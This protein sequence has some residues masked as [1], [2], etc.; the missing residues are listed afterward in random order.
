MIVLVVHNS[1]AK[2]SG[3]ETAV[4]NTVQLLSS[5]GHRVV[6]YGKSSQEISLMHLG[7]MWA[8]FSGIYSFKARREFAGLLR[9][10]RPDIVHIHNLFPLISP[11]ILP[12]C[13]QMG[14]PVVMSVHNYRLVCPDGLFMSKRARRPC[15]R[16]LGGR[17]YWCLLMNCE[18]NWCKSIG[19]AIRNYVARSRK[20]FLDNVSMY[21]CLT[22]F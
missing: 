2:P 19:Y 6:V 18:A 10:A 22:A 21:A 16:C 8:F 12:V 13:R 11:S 14:I 3:E 4:A 15:E 5:S 20:L 9:R 7:R 17:E 1:Y